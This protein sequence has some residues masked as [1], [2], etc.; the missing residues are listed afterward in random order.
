MADE[1][2]DTQSAVDAPP[3]VARQ[4]ELDKEIAGEKRSHH[5]IELSGMAARRKTAGKEGPEALVSKLG[6]GQ[7]FPVGKTVYGIPAGATRLRLLIRRVDPLGRRNSQHLRPQLRGRARSFRIRSLCAL[8]F[9]YRDAP[10][11]RAPNQDIPDKSP[12]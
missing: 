7:E 3:A 8:H 11:A 2:H 4:I 5:R 12:R 10:R 9:T 6:R 1:P